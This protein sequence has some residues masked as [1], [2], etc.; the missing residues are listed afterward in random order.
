MKSVTSDAAAGRIGRERFLDTR[1][2]QLDQLAG[3]ADVQRLV[4]KVL[5][6]IEAPAR[7][8][9]AAFNAGII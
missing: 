5:K 3:D 8:Q 7:V 2:I 9:V 4:I 1:D 6:D